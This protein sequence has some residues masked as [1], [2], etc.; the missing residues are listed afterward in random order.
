MTTA[1]RFILA[2]GSAIR[3]KVLTA[4]HVPFA[5]DAPHVDED[6]VKLSARADG[7]SVEDT[8]E[9]LAALKAE[10]VSARQPGALVLGCDQML[11]LEGDWLDKPADM[12]EAR[13]HLERMSGK[14]HHLVGGAVIY[15]DGQRIWSHRSRCGLT[16]RPL[17]EAYITWYLQ[18]AGEDILASVGAYMLEELG[19]Q[20]FERIDGDYFSILGTPLLPLLGFLRE[21]GVVPS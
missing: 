7:W 2:S 16:M 11:E 19:A 8:A 5:V 1:P 18:Q 15:L 3:A 17:G 21:H 14:T 6:A 10:K 9:A 4:A 20:L 12:T 13:S